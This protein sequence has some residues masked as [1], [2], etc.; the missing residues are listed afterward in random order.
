MVA[1]KGSSSNLHYRPT[2]GQVVKMVQA[3]QKMKKGG[4]TN[5]HK[6]PM[7]WEE[8]TLESEEKE[9]RSRVV[10]SVWLAEKEGIDKIKRADQ[11]LDREIAGSDAKSKE[12]LDNLDP[13]W[14][15]N[16]MAAIFA[17]RQMSEDWGD[18]L[19]ASLRS[20]GREIQV[21]W[22]SCLL[23]GPGSLFTAVCSEI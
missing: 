6:K 20:F 18:Q 8:L 19:D 11:A 14:E 22:H 17:H 10:A 13:T 23:S 12:M 16:K 21:C 9:R 5:T 15:R 1:G 2:I 3:A 4:Y 7:V